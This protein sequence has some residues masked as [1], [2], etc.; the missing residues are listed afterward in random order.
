VLTSAETVEGP[1]D[2]HGGIVIAARRQRLS[3]V[4]INHL[5][6]HFE[7]AHVLFER[8]HP[9]RILRWRLRRLGVRAVAGQ[10]L[11][12][13]FDR[14]FIAPRSRRRILEL[15]AH[16][17]V[18]APDGRIP[19][20]DVDS[21]NDPEAKDTIERLKP[22]VVV[23]SGVGIIRRS[24]LDLGPTFLNIHC[25]TTPRYRGVHGA[26]WA[27]AEG[28]SE[29]AGTTV[30]VLDE[31]VD[32]GPVVAQRTIVIDGDD[33]FRTLPVKQYLAG[34]DIMGDAVRQALGGALATLPPSPAASGN[35]WYSPTMRD[36][37]RFKRSLRRMCP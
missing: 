21:I 6:E 10:L 17:D 31:G 12:L 3:Y 19:T 26:F 22:A 11:F 24:V 34:L 29:A 1:R 9:L 35:Q 36:H 25:G 18:R 5:H 23:V 14:L 37:R 32:T 28:N 33:T 27:I 15:L 8:G 4:L 7:I 30:H 16:H 2:R 20:T 13:A